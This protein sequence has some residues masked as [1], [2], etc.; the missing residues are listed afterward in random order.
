MPTLHVVHSLHLHKG[1][2]EVEEVHKGHKEVEEVHQGY[3]EVE[4]T[5]PSLWQQPSSPS[6][7]RG[8]N[9]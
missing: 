1:H 2:K 7:T 5:A 9:G 3:K 4:D 8:W 6:M